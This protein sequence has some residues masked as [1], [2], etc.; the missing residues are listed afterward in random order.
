MI[1]TIVAML[2]GIV[3][4]YLD[5]PAIAQPVHLVVGSMLFIGAIF[6]KLRLE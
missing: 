6:F 2:A 4:N 3:M 1:C 5:M